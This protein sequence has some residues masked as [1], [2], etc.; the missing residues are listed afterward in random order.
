MATERKSQKTTGERRNPAPD[1]EAVRV[2]SSAGITVAITEHPPQFLKLEFGHE[3]L[4]KNDTQAE[5]KRT[6][7]LID[8][9]NKEELERRMGEYKRLIEAHSVEVGEDDEAP[10]GSVQDRARKRMKK[11]SE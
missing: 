3:R 10:A 2:W 9:F 5:I 7:R 11:R 6:A 8:E 1:D 4:A